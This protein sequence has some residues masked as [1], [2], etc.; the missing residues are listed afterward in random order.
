MYISRTR[1][2]DKQIKLSNKN[3][4]RYSCILYEKME[5]DFGKNMRQNAIKNIF[6]ENPIADF[7]NKLKLKS[8]KRGCIK[9]YKYGLV[10]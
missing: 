2:R 8:R 1:K 7:S 3:I 5:S 10:L 9:S 4:N 6:Y